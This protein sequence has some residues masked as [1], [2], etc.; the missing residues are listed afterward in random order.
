LFDLKAPHISFTQ[1]ARSRECPERWRLVYLEGRQ[2]AGPWLRDGKAVHQA[3]LEI[4]QKAKE[5]H[6]QGGLG[7]EDVDPILERMAGEF[8][9]HDWFQKMH[10][11]LRYYGERAT[12]DAGRMFGFELECRF[13]FQAL[14]REVVLLGVMDRLDED[15]YEFDI[16]E[17]KMVGRIPSREDLEDELQTG[18]YNLCRRH[19]EVKVDGEWRRLPRK[20]TGWRTWYSVFHRLAVRASATEQAAEQTHH[21]LIGA[22]EELLRLVDEGAPQFERR[23]GPYCMGCPGAADCIAWKQLRHGS[24]V[25]QTLTP[26]LGEYAQLKANASAVDKAKELLGDLVKAR[27]EEA[28]EGIIVE[29]GLKAELRA[30]PA[31]IGEE[32]DAI[33]QDLLRELG[34]LEDVLEGKVG[35]ELSPES[36]EAVRLRALR[37]VV[38]RI[39]DKATRGPSSRMTV[40]AWRELPGPAGTKKAPARRKEKAA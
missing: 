6:Q 15:A 4:S 37:E 7:V 3:I 17:N 23:T 8:S 35:A 14:G 20:A 9:S 31:G 24:G 39:R 1:L 28:P 5:Q 38:G 12:E 29:D 11:A 21:Y 10:A 26:T 22:T 33:V 13:K 36:A 40:K 27:L 32:W 25:G 2:E 18:L 30:Y 19:G 16:R 34:D